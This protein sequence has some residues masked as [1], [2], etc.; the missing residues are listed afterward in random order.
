MRSVSTTDSIAPL[1]ST[2]LARWLHS[3]RAL[4]LSVR[5]RRRKRSLQLCETLPLGE[6]RLLAVVQCEGHRFLI[7]ATNQ[8]ISVLERL[9]PGAAQR[10]KR[11][12]T[13]ESSFLSGV[14]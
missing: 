13:V 3:V 10:P 5:V 2:R 7:G 8:S 12:S 11:E 4:L 14:H 9:D 6:K 1:S